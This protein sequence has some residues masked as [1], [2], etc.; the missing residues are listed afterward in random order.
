MIAELRYEHMREQRWSGPSFF[1]GSEGMGRLND[2]L[3]G[4]AAHFGADMK[5]AFEVRGDIFEHLAFVGANPAELFA[6]TGRTHAF[7][8][9]GDHFL[10]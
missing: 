6:A 8:L 10:R 4:P 7:W 2:R 5:H 3:A 9:V 1:D